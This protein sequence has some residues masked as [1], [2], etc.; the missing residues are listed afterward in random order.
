[1]YKLILDKLIKPTN[2]IILRQVI[3]YLFFVYPCYLNMLF[4][5]SSISIS[6]WVI[7]YDWHSYI[8]NNIYH[9]IFS[10]YFIWCT[11]NM[12]CYRLSTSFVSMN[13]SLLNIY[14]CYFIFVYRTLTFVFYF[15]VICYF[16]YFLFYIYS[17]CS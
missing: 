4:V 11:S 2:I 15:V 8:E 14:C 9:Q 5:T 3:L 7:I 16:L 6:T 12:Y 13:F 1:M 10:Y 17:F